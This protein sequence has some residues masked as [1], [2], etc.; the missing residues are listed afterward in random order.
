RAFRRMTAAVTGIAC[1]FGDLATGIGGM[2][3]DLGEP[4]A[5]LFDDGEPRAAT[6]ALE[7]SGDAATVE[8]T[9]GDERLRATLAAGGGP[10]PP[11]PADGEPGGDLRVTACT[12]EIRVEAGN[13]TVAGTG[14]ISRWLD[15]PLS[16][17]GTFRCLTVETGETLLVATAQGE[18]GAEGHGEERALG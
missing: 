5:L 9:A 11:A 15:D 7:E 6:F 13:R 1:S 4:G 17:A 10:P 2:A 18:P 12:A 16:G 14:Q 8:L 3:W